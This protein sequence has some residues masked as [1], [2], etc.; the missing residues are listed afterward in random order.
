M[1]VTEQE[2]KNKNKE[3]AKQDLI[4]SN[5]CIIPSWIILTIILIVLDPEIFAPLSLNLVAIHIGLFVSYGVRVSRKAN[6]L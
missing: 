4:V 3:L 2:A 1:N 6:S 5:I